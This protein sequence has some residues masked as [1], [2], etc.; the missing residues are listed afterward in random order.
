MAR[1]KLLSIALLG[2]RNALRSIVAIRELAGVCG[3]RGLPGKRD[4]VAGSVGT[5]IGGAEGRDLGWRGEA[6]FLGVAAASLGVGRGGGAMVAA[7]GGGTGGFSGE[8][9]GVVDWVDSAG[10]LASGRVVGEWWV[11]L[12]GVVAAKVLVGIAK[13]VTDLV[14]SRS[15]LCHC[16]MRS[17]ISAAST[18]CSLYDS[19]MMEG[20]HGS[21][22]CDF[23]VLRTVVER[24]VLRAGLRV[25][26]GVLNVG[27]AWLVG[28]GILT[29]GLLR[30]VAGGIVGPLAI[31]AVGVCLFASPLTCGRACVV[32]IPDA[33]G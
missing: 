28:D 17:A 29:R 33:L 25:N 20:S 27:R 26:V 10:G 1:S 3:V 23:T 8:P 31:A 18:N 24:G 6:D 9:G 12:L 14:F 11:V 19:E 15:S 22:G 13:V 21:A 16:L 32:V 7:L 4:S 2:V 5:T 30:E